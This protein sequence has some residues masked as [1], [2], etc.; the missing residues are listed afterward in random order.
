MTSQFIERNCLVSNGQSWVGEQYPCSE[1]RSLGESGPPSVQEPVAALIRVGGHPVPQR[2][3]VAR[4]QPP[5][6]P[7]DEVAIP[8]AHTPTVV[9]ARPAGSAP[10]GAQDSSGGTHAWTADTTPGDPQH[11]GRLSKWHGNVHLAIH[12]EVRW[13]ASTRL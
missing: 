11:E 6:L 12:G 4:R 10:A 5:P 9:R 3:L 8:E 7:G 1:L 2:R 13:L